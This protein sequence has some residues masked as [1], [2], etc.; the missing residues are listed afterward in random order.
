MKI[1]SIIEEQSIF[2]FTGKINL[3]LR[4]NHQY[5]G[6]IFLINGNVVH[7]QL[8]NIRGKHALLNFLFEAFDNESKFKYVI[9][10][11]VVDI[12]IASFNYSP[13]QL[14]KK[15]NILSHKY[16]QT[17]RLRPPD[18]LRVILSGEFIL[19]GPQVTPQEFELMCTISDYNK[20]SEI[21]QNCP[22]YHFEITSRLVSLRKNRALKVI[23][24]S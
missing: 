8:G 17:S 2:G 18:N 10:P 11:E 7:A 5:L 1:I 15:I 23:S 4:N 9:E 14:I 6:A 20:I 13:Q 24:N 22:L 19:E 3:L 16:Q 21:Y 12:K